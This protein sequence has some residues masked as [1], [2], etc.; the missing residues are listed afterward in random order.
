MT[1]ETKCVILL[2]DTLPIGLLA[3]TAAILGLSLGKIRPELIG[4]NTID[5]AQ[6][7]HAGIISIPVPILKAASEQLADLRIKLYHEAFREIEV[8]GFTDVAQKC[9]QYE[10][11]SENFKKTTPNELNY[12][13]LGLYGPK[14]AI[15]K[16]TGSLPLLR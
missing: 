7:V 16:L 4:A 10:E 15:N 14:K 8:V 6:N 11:Y 12:M 9:N 3:N 13:G 5:A 1:Q 2:D